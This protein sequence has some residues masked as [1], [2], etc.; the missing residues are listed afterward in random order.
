MVAAGESIGYGCQHIVERN[1]RI[2]VLPIGYA[3]GIPRN[4]GNKRGCVLLHG[5]RAPIIGSVCMDQLM[6]DV[7]DIPAIECADIATLIG[8]DGEEEI[9]ADD[10]A[11]TAGTIPNE[12]LS[13]LSNRLERVFIAP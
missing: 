10:V 9:L 6:V 13:R 12:I 11:A 8:R 4:L 5:Q 7:T 1:T 3:D 2:A